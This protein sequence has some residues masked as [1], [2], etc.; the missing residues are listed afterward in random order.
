MCRSDARLEPSIA[1]SEMF[2]AVS[3]LLSSCIS[4]PSLLVL[5]EWGSIVAGEIHV[6]WC[7]TSRARRGW[8]EEGQHRVVQAVVTRLWVTRERALAAD[9]MDLAIEGLKEIRDDDGVGNG[10]SV[11]LIR[12]FDHLGQWVQS[13]KTVG[14]FAVVGRAVLADQAPDGNVDL[15]QAVVA[16]VLSRA[17]FQLCRDRERIG[18]GRPRLRCRRVAGA[19]P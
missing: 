17:R 7:R 8:S 4:A 13:G 14:E 6:A 3:R 9:S 1:A 2:D 18:C 19:G 15:P 12:K 11:V 16:V 10:G 5:G